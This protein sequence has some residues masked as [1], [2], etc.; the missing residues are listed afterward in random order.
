ML[1]I[2]IALGVYIIINQRKKTQLRNELL[3]AEINELRL[4]IKQLIDYQPEKSSISID[5]LNKSLKEPLSD[6]EFEVL[7]M[8]MTD[9]NNSEIAEKIFVSTNTVKYHLKNVYQKLGVSNRKEALK[10]A[11]Q[12]TS[13]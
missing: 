4:Q 2:T 1:T 13:R 8:A 9:K 11:F 6:R 5:Q 7:Q 10:F 3:T 12:A